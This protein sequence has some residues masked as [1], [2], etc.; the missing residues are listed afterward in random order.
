MTVTPVDGLP[1]YGTFRGNDDLW[2]TWLTLRHWL[3]AYDV[4]ELPG[5]KPEIIFEVEGGAGLTGAEVLA[6]S[7][8]RSALYEAF[9]R[10][11]ET[12]DYVVLPTAQVMPFDAKLHWPDHIGDVAM[13]SYHRWMEVTTVATL[14]N[15]P[16]VVLPAGFSHDGLPIGL[17]VI[18]RNHGELALLD[19]ARAWERATPWSEH[20]PPLLRTP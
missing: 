8:K 2:P 12:Y 18:G 1:A 15:A 5:L 7:V 11:F 6:A 17:Q 10:M 16:A 4:S 13:T 9:R 3:S 20:L 14:I 19:L